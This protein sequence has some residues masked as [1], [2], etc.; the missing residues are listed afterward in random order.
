MEHIEH[1]EQIETHR[2]YVV[3]TKPR[4]ETLVQCQ[5]QHKGVPLFFPKLR[6]PP[7][8]AKQPQLIPLFPNYLF[9]RIEAA[10]QYDAVRWAPGVRYV[11][12][13]NGT[14]A[15]VDDAA[16]AFLQQ[17]ADTQ[18]V[19]TACSTL[20]TGQEVLIREGPFAGLTG[21]I[22]YPPDAKGRVKVL[23]SLLGRQV[24][25]PVPAAATEG[26]AVTSPWTIAERHAA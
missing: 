9:V 15:P 23:L 14:P 21:I 22:E 16:I 6:L 25:V 7:S 1:M 24:T 10:W 3:Y 26:V 2:W 13:F 8:R 12:N 18:G 17:H 11:V 20:Q 4:K 19:L 5:V